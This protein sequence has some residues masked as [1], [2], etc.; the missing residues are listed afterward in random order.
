MRDLFER[1]L[2]NLYNSELL[3]LHALPDMLE[4]V[5]DG[6]LAEIIETYIQETRNQKERLVEIGNYLHIKF[7]LTNGKIIRGLLKEM[8]DLYEDFQKGMLL[9]VG[10][11]AKLQHVEHFQ[12]SAYE[13][14]LLYAKALDVTEVAEK[15]DITLWE[16]YEA[17]EI[18]GNY[19]KNLMLNNK[20]KRP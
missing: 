2:Q 13:T 7:Q 17:D 1:Q 8:K 11:V 4:H 15:L 6:K 16:A 12:I 9:D 10:I 20:W 3:I 18:C 14:A 19:A 5:T